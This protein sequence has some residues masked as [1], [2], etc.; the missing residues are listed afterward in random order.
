MMIYALILFSVT[1]VLMMIAGT[2]GLVAIFV[3]SKMP[4]LSAV[5]VLLIAAS[6]IEN[7]P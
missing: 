3:E 2:M 1:F 4:A 7:K 5:L 6:F